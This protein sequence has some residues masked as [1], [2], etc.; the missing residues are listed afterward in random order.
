V[1]RRVQFCRVCQHAKGRRH[2]IGLYTP[3]LIPEVPWEDINM[4]FML[5][6][7]RTQRGNDYIFVVVDRFSKM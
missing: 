6:L 5:G 3:L 1:K 7:S 4:D 2:I